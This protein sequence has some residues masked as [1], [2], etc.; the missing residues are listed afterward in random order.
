MPKKKEPPPITRVFSG[1]CQK[2]D[3][4]VRVAGHRGAC[5]LGVMEEEEYEVES[6]IA[7]RRIAGGKLVKQGGTIQFLIKWKDWPE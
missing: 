4:C 3:G 6:I 5:K 7:E 2:R 1:Q